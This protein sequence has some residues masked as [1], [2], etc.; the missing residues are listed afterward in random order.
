MLLEI[1]ELSK[2]FASVP[3]LEDVTFGLKAGSI[4]ALCGGNGAGKSTFFNTI[5]GIYQKN[6]GTI[7]FKGKEV[8][9]PSPKEAFEHGIAIVQQELSEIPH[10]T[11]AENIF[12]AREPSCLS[13]IN[14]KEQVQKAQ[15]I[16]DDLGF[17]INP[18]IK[19]FQLSVADKQLVE[20][21]KA[22][23]HNAEI[24]IMDEPTSALDTEDTERLFKVLR[25]LA[26]QGKS[27]IYVSHRLEEIFDIADS[28]TMFRDGKVVGTG[29]V[30]DI[31]R[32][33]LIELMIGTNLEQEFVKENIP[34]EEVVFTTKNMN[35][36]N[37]LFDMSLDIKKGEIFGIY[38]LVG[39]GRS[40]FCNA[41]FGLE[42]LATG[43][44]EVHGQS[45]K[46]TAKSAID[47]K[48][49]YITEDRKG[50]GL[51]LS[52]SVYDNISLTSL[53]QNTP[54]FFINRHKEKS[55]VTQMIEKF[56]IR[57]ASPYQIVRRL[58]GGN[59]QKVVLGQWIL[60][61]PDI[62]IMDEPTRGI[63]VG[64]KRE[65]YSFM[66]DFACE[67]KSVLMVSSDIH[68]VMGMCDRIAVFKHGRLVDILD[69][70]EFTQ[71]KLIN[72]AA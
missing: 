58:S 14:H 66:S 59:Q 6:K 71:K 34:A 19:M 2:S 20:I 53:K 25:E 17:N 48:I 51:V 64:A 63:D 72:L 54:Y 47:N 49:A 32:A 4:H 23:S 57:L 40:E 5:M 8:N 28:W 39:A 9:F 56:H 16:L 52:S 33:D 42:P 36:P 22:L 38:G 13:F 10:L 7:L 43:E 41:I 1:K 45:I 21:A 30:E 44:V 50:S 67:G 37:R 26:E 27:I 31:T 35:I 3:A 70:S 69:R 24:I 18:N 11:V 46:R 62:L 61:E 60:T 68:E 55:R 15:K 65:I 29:L 12:L